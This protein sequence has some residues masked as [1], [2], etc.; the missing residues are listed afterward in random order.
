MIIIAL[1]QRG[2]GGSRRLRCFRFESFAHISEH[3]HC[4]VILSTLCLGKAGSAYMKQ[5]GNDSGAFCEQL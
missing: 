3:V 5:A 4:I 2:Y 1:E